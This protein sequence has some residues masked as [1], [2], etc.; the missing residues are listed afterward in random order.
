[1]MPCSRSQA[2]TPSA[3]SL[4]RI[5]T[6]ALGQRETQMGQERARGLDEKHVAVADPIVAAAAVAQG[7][8]RREMSGQG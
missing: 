4:V 7:E 8:L 5:A 3:S 1:M 2:Q 6:P